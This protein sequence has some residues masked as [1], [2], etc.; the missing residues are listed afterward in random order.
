MNFKVGDRVRRIERPFGVE[1][2]VGK[3]ST[4][5]EIIPRM[6]AVRLG[7]G[8]FRTEYYELEE[9]GLIQGAIDE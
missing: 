2:P 7:N 6:G 4:V 3:I 5:K 9:V 8:W 1:Q